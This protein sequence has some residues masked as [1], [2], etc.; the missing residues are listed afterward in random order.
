MKKLI[1][2]SLESFLNKAL[3]ENFREALWRMDKYMP[4]D[5]NLIQKWNE[6]LDNKEISYKEKVDEIIQFLEEYADE[7]ILRRYIK[8]KSLRDF[9]E[10][11]VK[12]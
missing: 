2:E 12:E 10:F 11:I 7:E 4:D 6:I 5:W 9:A 3:N 8:A 1:S